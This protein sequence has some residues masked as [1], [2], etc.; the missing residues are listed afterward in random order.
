M[1]KQRMFRK[2]RTR[3]QNTYYENQDVNVL[4]TLLKKIYLKYAVSC[5]AA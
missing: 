5:R 2:F 4:E 1:K 3:G